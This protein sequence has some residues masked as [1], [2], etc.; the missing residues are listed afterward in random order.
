MSFSRAL[1]LVLALAAAPFWPAQ[2]QFGGMP[3]MPGSPA[4]ASPFGA[5]PQPQQPPAACQNLLVLREEV[6]KHGKALQAAGQAKKKPTPD[7]ACKL[8]KAYLGAEGKFLKSLEQN[9]ATCGVPPDA[10]K[11]M[12]ASHVKGSEMGKNVCEAAARGPQQAGPSFS[13]VLG[14]TPVTP[15]NTDRLKRGPGTFDTLTG[16]PL[17]Q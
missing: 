9:S 14:T 2:A 8:F 6:Q 3:G 13:E 5:A 11:Q 15:E 17:G 12:K 16:N 7:E 1:P 4:P 10:I